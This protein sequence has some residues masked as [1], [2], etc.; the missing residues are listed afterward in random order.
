MRL[1]WGRGLGGG[2]ARQAVKVLQQHLAPNTLTAPG[3]S[4]VTNSFGFGAAH[5]HQRPPR[6]HRH[7]AR[8]PSRRRPVSQPR[9]ANGYPD[10]A[11]RPGRPRSASHSAQQPRATGAAAYAAPARP[12]AG[13]GFGRAGCRRL[14]CVGARRYAGA[15]PAAGR[16]VASFSRIKEAGGRLLDSL[17][18]AWFSSS[19]AKGNGCGFYCKLLPVNKKAGSATNVMRP[20]SCCSHL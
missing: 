14:Q 2:A 5:R 9:P 12:V 6:A 16:A 13:I 3:V 10:A 8:R 18:P 4:T 15:Y 11:R 20:F 1:P 17:P 19:R 7:A